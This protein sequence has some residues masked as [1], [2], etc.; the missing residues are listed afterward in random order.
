MTDLEL[1]VISLTTESMSIDCKNSLYYQIV[2]DEIINVIARSQ[3]IKKEERYSYFKEIRTI[4]A[5]FFDDF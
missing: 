3:L 1:V 2:F 5:S 4:L